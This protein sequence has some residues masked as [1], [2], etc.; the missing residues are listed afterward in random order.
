MWT[1]RANMNKIM[2]NAVQAEISLIWSNI[3][4]NY[5]TVE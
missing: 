5:L 4:H 2:N 1:S 3:V